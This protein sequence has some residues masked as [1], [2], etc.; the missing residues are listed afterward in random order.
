MRWTRMI[1]VALGVAI[2]SGCQPAPS[3]PLES[4]SPA[5]GSG[6]VQESPAVENEKPKTPTTVQEWLDW[7][8]ANPD[9]QSVEGSQPGWLTF[10]HLKSKDYWLFSADESVAGH[11]MGV[12]RRIQDEPV[13][14]IQMRVLCEGDP[15]GCEEVTLQANGLNQALIARAKT[16][17]EEDQATAPVIDPKV[18]ENEEA[19]TEEVQAQEVAPEEPVQENS[20]AE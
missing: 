4:S 16:V 20:S 7:V 1:S 5:P 13:F 2:L 8:K 17:Q 9:Y 19:S 6:L 14:D 18:V 3:S 10:R 15:K 12:F 11:P